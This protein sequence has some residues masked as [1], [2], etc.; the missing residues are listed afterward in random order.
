MLKRSAVTLTLAGALALILD[1]VRAQT[2]NDDKAP[3]EGLSKS[4]AELNERI[5]GDEKNV[6]IVAFHDEI[7]CVGEQRV[8]ILGIDVRRCRPWLPNRK[9]NQVP[10]EL[11]A[12][13][14]QGIA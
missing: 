4:L 3:Q 12:F 1:P 10:I 6:S 5:E 2:D 9:T 13:R 8:V 14:L 11:D 7:G